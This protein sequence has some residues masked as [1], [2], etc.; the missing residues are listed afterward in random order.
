MSKFRL[1]GK[2]PSEEQLHAEY[3]RGMHKERERIRRAVSKYIRRIEL[4][5]GL[6]IRDEIAL[7][8]TTLLDIINGRK[9]DV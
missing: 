8:A 7:D 6:L 4:E 1:L 9:S 5:P 2:T 3:L